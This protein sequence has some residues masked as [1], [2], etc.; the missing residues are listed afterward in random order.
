MTQHSNGS[1]LSRALPDPR[2]GKFGRGRA[3]SGTML[4]PSKDMLH[5]VLVV[6]GHEFNPVVLALPGSGLVP[7]EG[8]FQG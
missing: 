6:A 3:W 1:G 2:N 4:D 7:V 8:H 5:D